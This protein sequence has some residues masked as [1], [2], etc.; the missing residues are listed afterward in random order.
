VHDGSWGGR[1]RPCHHVLTNYGTTTFSFMSR[2]IK[3]KEVFL[4]KSSSIH[5]FLQLSLLP[6]SC[7]VLVLPTLRLSAS[8]AVSRTERHLQYI[9]AYENTAVGSGEHTA[10]FWIELHNTKPGVLPRQPLHL[11]PAAPLVWNNCLHAELK[12]V[13][14]RTAGRLPLLQEE[15]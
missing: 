12:A 15:D 4:K 10:T 8:G 11:A 2:P 3:E 9:I 1:L 6:P 13:A 7:L 14:T 5:G